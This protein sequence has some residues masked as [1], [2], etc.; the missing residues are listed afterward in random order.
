MLSRRNLNLFFLVF[1]II[2]GGALVYSYIGIY[3]PLINAVVKTQSSVTTITKE[4][5]SI[6]TTQT[7]DTTELLTNTAQLQKK[8]PVAELADQFVLQLEKVEVASGSRIISIAFNKE[9]QTDT[10]NSTAEQ[11]I[12][13]AEQAHQKAQTA[14]DLTKDNNSTQ[15][16]QTTIPAGVKKLTVTMSVESPSY[17]ELETF[18]K[19]LEEL[20][21]I[22]KVESLAFTGVAEDTTSN[23]LTYSVVASTY[24]YPELTDLR[25]QLPVYQAP[26]PSNKKNPLYQAR[27]VVPQ[28][29]GET[30]GT[31]NAQTKESGQTNHSASIQ[32]N[33]QVNDNSQTNSPKASKIITKNGKQYKVTTYKVQPGDSLFQLAVKYYNNSKG[34]DLIKSW[35]GITDLQANETIEIPVPVDGEI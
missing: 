25:N 15:T 24:Y 28:T 19:E 12:A 34:M 32:Q 22:T 13:A 17:V 31:Q 35:N 3:R 16:T 5:S 21:R 26:D 33:A 2:F 27:E 23:V 1:A 9:D 14:M 20:P 11:N 8:L 29:N 6:K 4:I 18:I 7:T 30:T 10:T